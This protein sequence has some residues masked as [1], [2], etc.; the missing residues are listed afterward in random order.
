MIAMFLWFYLN[1]P[2]T[3]Y[4]TA[5]IKELAATISDPV[6]LIIEIEILN[7]SRMAPT[8]TFFIILVLILSIFLFVPRVLKSLPTYILS[9]EFYWRDEIASYNRKIGVIR[10]ISVTI[11]F[12]VIIGIIANLFSGFLFLSVSHLCADRFGSS[13]GSMGARA[14][15]VVYLKCPVEFKASPL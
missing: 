14:L 9:N 6:E 13:G 12:G 5:Q 15:P 2:R 8:D 7:S 1:I 3:E 10:F 4:Y 11:I